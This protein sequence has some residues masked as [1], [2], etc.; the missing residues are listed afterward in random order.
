MLETGQ[1]GYG[2]EATGLGD[3]WSRTVDDLMRITAQ[4]QL[5]VPGLAQGKQRGNSAIAFSIDVDGTGPVIESWDYGAPPAGNVP[6]NPE[7][8]RPGDG[9]SFLKIGVRRRQGDAGD[10][11]GRVKRDD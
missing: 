9:I 4:Q 3:D 2:R 7:D 1:T 6:A 8:E 10:M 11:P 5:S